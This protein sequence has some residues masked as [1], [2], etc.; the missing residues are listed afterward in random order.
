[1]QFDTAPRPSHN[2]R[3]G[4][5]GV[6]YRLLAIDVGSGTQ[7][8]L[9]YE[10]GQ[11]LENN[12][13]LVLPS[14]TVVLARRIA[15]ATARRQPL[16]LW[17]QVMGG[18]PCVRAIN[19]HLRAGLPV[20]ATPAA[21]ATIRDDL[22]DVQAMGVQIVEEPPAGEVVSLEM[23]DVDLDALS[24]ALAPFEETLPEACAVAVQDHGECFDMSQRRFRFQ[25]WEQF[26]RDGG[27]LEAMAYGP[28]E[29][30]PYLTRMLALQ[31]LLPGAL[32]MDT[33]AAAIHGAM[34]D[35]L[36]DAQRAAGL[37]VL[38]MG[39][40][41]VLGALVRGHRVYGVF[42]HHTGLVDLGQIIELVAA[43]REG[44][45]TN[46]EVYADGGHGAYIA[47][48]YPGHFHFLAVTGPRRAMT[49]P[50]EPYFAAPLGNMMLS[51]A[52]GLLAAALERHDLPLPEGY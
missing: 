46:D 30:P 2:Q 5:V 34:L 13:Q 1:M 27:D 37:I 3:N 40:E 52:Y 11:P 35:P 19:D 42:E 41:H 45:L 23:K 6:A 22:A 33:G 28:G 36:V 43:L 18:G 32:V 26:L 4:G 15:R 50:M 21:A 31:T 16:F 10:E 12:I 39:N 17:G 20:Y 29:V 47:P 25:H 51:G 24:Q 38:N 48:D 8:V 14:Q 44:R 49:R 9:I 7:D